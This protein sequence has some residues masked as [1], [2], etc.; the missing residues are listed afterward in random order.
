[1]NTH[2][3]ET[4]VKAPNQ[5][6]VKEA[7][8]SEKAIAMDAWGSFLGIHSRHLRI[9]IYFTFIFVVLA[10]LAIVFLII[11]FFHSGGDQSIVLVGLLLGLTSIPII[12][13]IK[14]RQMMKESTRI[15]TEFERSYPDHARYI[16][17]SKK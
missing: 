3:T 5:V 16:H 15:F 1:M 7:R 14:R 12:N 13:T 17:L 9:M 4:V 10:F 8:E 11:Y 2:T 6:L